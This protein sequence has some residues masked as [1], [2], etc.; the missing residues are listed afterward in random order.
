[1]KIL[2]GLLVWLSIIQ[3]NIEII[4]LSKLYTIH[5][6]FILQNLFILIYFEIEYLYTIIVVIKLNKVLIS[7][8]KYSGHSILVY[9]QVFQTQKHCLYH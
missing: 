4:F 3:S 9:I 2:S 1:M 6:L 7:N 5:L 8:C